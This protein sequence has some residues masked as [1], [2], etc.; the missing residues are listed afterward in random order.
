MDLQFLV[1]FFPFFASFFGVL[2]AFFLQW[3]GRRY[4]RREDRGKF[5]R[6]IRHELETGSTWLTGAGQLLPTDMF[7][8]GKL[9]GFL[10]R[11]KYETKTKIASIYFSI[12]SHNYESEKVRDIGILSQLLSFITKGEIPTKDLDLWVKTAYRLEKNEKDLKQHIED[13]LKENIWE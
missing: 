1:P 6:D 4:D 2:L 9:S 5:L 12:E 11:L 13:L 3:L 7:E 8:S 10:T